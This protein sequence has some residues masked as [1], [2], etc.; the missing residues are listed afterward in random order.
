MDFKTDGTNLDLSPLVSGIY[1]I[2]LFNK[3]KSL[4]KQKI[5]KL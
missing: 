4:G 5:I 1:I 3:G 2:E